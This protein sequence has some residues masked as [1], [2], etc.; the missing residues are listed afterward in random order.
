MEDVARYTIILN[1]SVMS[2]NTKFDK[3]EGGVF[4]AY[5]MFQDLAS[6]ADQVSIV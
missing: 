1:T 6:S 5:K 2:N 4:T 3:C